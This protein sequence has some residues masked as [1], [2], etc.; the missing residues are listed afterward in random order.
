MTW[1]QDGQL[2]LL[3]GGR[4]R[5]RFFQSF[6]VTGGGYYSKSIPYKWIRSDSTL[7]EDQEHRFGFGS[8]PGSIKVS[9]TAEKQWDMFC[10]WNGNRRSG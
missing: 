3:R 1:K 6:L 7:F 4:A 5:A 10:S 9:V 2:R 8:N